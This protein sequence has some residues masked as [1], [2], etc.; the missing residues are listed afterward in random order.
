MISNIVSNGYHVV[1]VSHWECPDDV[2]QWRLSFSTAEVCLLNS[3]SPVQQI[4]Y[5]VLRFFIKTID[6]AYDNLNKPEKV[7]HNYH[8]K[9]VDVVGVWEEVAQVVDHEISGFDMLQFAEMFL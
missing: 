2:Y 5:H 1:P 8:L 6:N 3:W 7:I 9:T 4:I